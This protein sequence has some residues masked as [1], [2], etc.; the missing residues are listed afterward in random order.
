MNN[1]GFT[2]VELIVSIMLY[3]LILVLFTTS[4]LAFTRLY[5][6]VSKL[7]D[8][9]NDAEVIYTIIDKAYKEK[10]QEIKLEKRYVNNLLV[11]VPSQGKVVF[12]YDITQSDFEALM[13]KY[14]ADGVLKG[15]FTLS[16]NELKYEV[17]GGT[18]KAVVVYDGTETEGEPDEL[19]YP[20]TPPTEP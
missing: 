13:A 3:S 2:L 4:V 8:V 9:A 11:D 14:N 1:K 20:Y 15:T 12:K 10:D 18:G 17:D 19:T 6:L 16:K 5:E 7:D